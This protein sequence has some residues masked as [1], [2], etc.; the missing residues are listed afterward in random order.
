MINIHNMA[1]FQTLQTSKKYQHVHWRGGSYKKVWIFWLYVGRIWLLINNLCSTFCKLI[2]I[3]TTAMTRELKTSVYVILVSS[4]IFFHQNTLYFALRDLSS[5]GGDKYF[6]TGQNIL[7]IENICLFS[8]F[9]TIVKWF[10][11]FYFQIHKSKN[12]K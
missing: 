9:S 12:Q 1:L 6:L 3:K 11:N 7:E 4:S 10:I 5:Q 8:R 2:K